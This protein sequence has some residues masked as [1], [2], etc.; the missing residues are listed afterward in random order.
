MADRPADVSLDSARA[1]ELL[2]TRLPA[3]RDALAG[4]DPQGG[5]G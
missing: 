2:A 4:A 3:I 5:A 1:R